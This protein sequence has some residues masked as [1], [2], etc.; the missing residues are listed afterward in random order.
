[1]SLP[2]FQLPF[3][4]AEFLRHYWQQQPLVMQQAASGLLTPSKEELFAL[5]QRDDVESRIITGA[6]DGPWSLQQGP[7]Q[8]E[9][10]T[11]LPSK[12]WTLLVQSVDYYLSNI[13]LLLDSFSFLP[14]WR[15]EDIMISYATQGGSVGPHYDR[16]DVFL[17]Q[18]HGQRRWHLGPVCDKSSARQDVEDIDLLKDMPIKSTHLMQP[19]D[20]LYLPPGVAHWGIAED[21]ECITWSV[22]FRAPRLT[23]LLARL[24]DEVL[25][26]NSPSLYTDQGRS[27]PTNNG[28][29]G[30]AEAASLNQQALS[31][32]NKEAAV[33]AYCE[34]LTEPR[35]YP[36]QTTLQTDIIHHEH[37]DAEFVRQG[38]VRMLMSDEGLWVNGFFY[39]LPPS[40][41]EFG[42]FLAQQRLYAKSELD[43]FRSEHS[44]VQAMLDQWVEQGY[45]A[46]IQRG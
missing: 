40:L 8:A 3:G 9:D 16:Y 14:S 22:G 31:L 24:T 43:T 25:A 33:R 1:M 35:Q 2:R 34:L 4:A 15:H 13:S 23:D 37:P 41:H 19:G 20:V 10:F 28:Y 29:F 39:E 18:A 45:L 44:N 26:D 7:F 32:L 11:E 17:I 6:N 46:P 38:G 12:E 27:L 42:T 30:N 36:E 21:D 5:A